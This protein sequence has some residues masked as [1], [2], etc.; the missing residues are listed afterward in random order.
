[1]IAGQCVCALPGTAPDIVLI[2]PKTSAR[3]SNSMSNHN[4]QIRI[5]SWLSADD[6]AVL[7]RTIAPAIIITA[8]TVDPIELPWKSVG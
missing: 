1:M 4:F 3:G 5:E 7:R 6:R 2:A 8:P